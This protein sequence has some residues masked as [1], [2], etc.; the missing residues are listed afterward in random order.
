MPTI[1]KRLGALLTIGLFCLAAFPVHGIA[2]GTSDA[3]DICKQGGYTEVTTSSGDSFDNTGDCV[4]YAAQ[5]NEFG[6][7]ET[8]EVTP[9]PSP[10]VTPEPSPEVTP[11]PE[12]TPVPGTVIFGF[13]IVVPA[14]GWGCDIEVSGSAP[15]YDVVYVQIIDL[16]RSYGPY[17][18][19]VANQAALVNPDGSFW[20]YG[21]YW[22][23][24][25]ET[26]FWVGVYDARD[27]WSSDTNLLASSEIATCDPS[28]VAS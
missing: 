12:Q 23:V 6:E 21:D 3:A 25:E 13:E 24:F 20:W 1:L 28:G 19:Y 9:E 14:S 15:G 10:D 27:Y 16:G 17:P 7:G 2:E 11:E 4:S 18:V 8:I 5:G 22:L 26:D